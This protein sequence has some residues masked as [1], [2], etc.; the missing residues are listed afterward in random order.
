[1]LIWGEKVLVILVRLHL[2]LSLGLS[3][4]TPLL[5]LKPETIEGNTYMMN[6]QC[7]IRTWALTLQSS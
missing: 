6:I 1:M 2:H 5:Q 7:E 4:S 3:S